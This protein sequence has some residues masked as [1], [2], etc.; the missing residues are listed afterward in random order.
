METSTN[1]VKK[2]MDELN[3]DSSLSEEQNSTNAHQSQDLFQTADDSGGEQGYEYSSAQ[4]IQN[5]FQKVKGYEG[6]EQDNPEFDTVGESKKPKWSRVKGTS[7]IPKEDK[8]FIINKLSER[9]MK[10]KKAKKINEHRL[11]LL[12]E[13]FGKNFQIT[14]DETYNL[15]KFKYKNKRY[16]HLSEAL[17]A[18]HIPINDQSSHNKVDKDIQQYD[19]PKVERIKEI[20]EKGHQTKNINKKEEKRRLKEGRDMLNKIMEPEQFKRGLHFRFTES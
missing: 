7:P 8:Q 20:R 18:V 5:D 4:E 14:F 6:Q 12:V 11:K 17:D 2:V 9:D 1:S 3:F 15:K 19:K 13:K 16:G 10:L